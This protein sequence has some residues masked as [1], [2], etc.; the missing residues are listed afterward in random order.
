MS[1][2]QIENIQ[3]F[4]SENWNL[5]S[6]SRNPISTS[7]S[8]KIIGKPVKKT[9]I[10]LS[11]EDINKLSPNPIKSIRPNLFELAKKNNASNS[12]RFAQSSSPKNQRKTGDCYCGAIIHR[13][14]NARNGDWYVVCSKT[15]IS[16]RECNI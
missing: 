5:A 2:P 10:V 14:Q 16:I 1:P 12:D 13:I 11:F 9:T 3:D 6:A 8:R 4:R 15:H 7:I